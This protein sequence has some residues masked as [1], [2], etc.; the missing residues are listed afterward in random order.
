VAPMAYD[1]PDNAARL[2]RLGVSETLPAAKF[3]SGRAAALLR[4]I[5]DDTHAASCLAIKKRLAAENALAR[6]AEII[7]QIFRGIELDQPAIR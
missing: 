7:E 6:S 4:R 2:K 5:M 1:Q 3:S